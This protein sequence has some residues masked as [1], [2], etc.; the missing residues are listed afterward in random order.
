M[1]KIWLKI[2]ERARQKKQ[3]SNNRATKRQ[4]MQGTE[5]AK[6][7]NRAPS[8]GVGNESVRSSR[9]RDA[10][11]GA[12]NRPQA[13]DGQRQGRDQTVTLGQRGHGTALMM[14]KSDIEPGAV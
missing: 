2:A 11:T 9:S 4:V 14:R 3:E 5:K 12:G 10:A 7:E 1:D 6:E 13:R 8:R